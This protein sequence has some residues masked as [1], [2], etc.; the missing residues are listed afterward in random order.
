MIELLFTE[1]TQIVLKPVHRKSNHQKLVNFQVI[2]SYEARADQGY[3]GQILGISFQKC[4]DE[5]TF[6]NITF[7]MEYFKIMHMNWFG[8]L[9]SLC[10]TQLLACFLLV[11]ERNSQANKDVCHS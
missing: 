10:A 9:A 3:V 6:K 2:L 5:S 11:T 7:R 1:E 4:I 8:K